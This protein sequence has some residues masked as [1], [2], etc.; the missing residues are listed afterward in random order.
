LPIV[1]PGAK[2]C[3]RLLDM[4]RPQPIGTPIMQMN[5]N[6]MANQLMW[7]LMSYTPMNEGA[8]QP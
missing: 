1:N 5:T 4:I 6:L 7:Y 3:P 2:K 8:P